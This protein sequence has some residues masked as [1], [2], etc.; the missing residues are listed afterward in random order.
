MVLVKLA[1]ATICFLNQCYPM[2]YGTSTPV[3]EYELNLRLTSTPGYGG[4]VIQFYD[5]EDRLL[6][7]HRIW[8]LS[9]KQERPERMLSFDPK[10]HI[11]TDGCINVMPDVY[12]KLKDCCSNDHLSIVP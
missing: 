7:I 3:G 8:L 12:E 4:D 1:T 10:K 11:I 6:V 9:P 2:L 5:E